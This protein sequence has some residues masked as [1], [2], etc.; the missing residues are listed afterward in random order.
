M[1]SNLILLIVIL[2]FVSSITACQIEERSNEDMSGGFD[3]LMDSLSEGGFQIDETMD[4]SNDILRGKNRV[5]YLQD[6]TR[7]DVFEY[8]DMD[9]LKEDK[10]GISSDGTSISISSETSEISW[11]ATPHFYHLDDVI[12]LYVGDQGELIN[13][14]VNLTTE[15]ITSN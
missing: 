15:S 11:V 7:I 6:K 14:L 3:Q 9:M 13:C 1:K 10:S 5:I 8:I 2:W 12:I 4:G